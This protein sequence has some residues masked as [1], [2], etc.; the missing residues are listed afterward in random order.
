MENRIGKEKT[1]DFLLSAHKVVFVKRTG[2]DF[3]S[4]L[5]ALLLIHSDLATDSKC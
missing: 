3:W 5:F 4:L 1:E 2:F